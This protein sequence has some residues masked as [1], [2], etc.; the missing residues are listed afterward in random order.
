MG[1]KG[2]KMTSRTG[3]EQR[4]A[5][6]VEGTDKAKNLSDKRYSLFAQNGLTLVE[7]LLAVAI[8][9]IGIISVLRGYANALATLEAGQFTIDATNLTKN[10]MAE[11]ELA[12]MEEEE[13]P[14]AGEAGNFEDP[15]DDFM[16]KWT[17]EPLETD[18]L[19][20]LALTVSH[21]NNPRTME[22]LTYVAD[23]ER[24]EETQ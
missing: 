24:P 2:P 20:R 19:H 16:W 1:S 17:I 7:V 6:S 13:L 18:G 14:T 11:I 22:L 9:A 3:K 23:K 10:K 21:Q 15:F 5:C 8:M 4:I 12:L